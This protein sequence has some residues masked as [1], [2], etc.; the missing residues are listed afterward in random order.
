MKEPFIVF[1]I[2]CLNISNLDISNCNNIIACIRP[3][4]NKT[5]TSHQLNLLNLN[6]KLKFYSVFKKDC[7]KTDLLRKKFFNEINDKYPNFNDLDNISKILFLFNN[8]DPSVELL[9]LIFMI[10]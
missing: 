3:T 6:K 9:L 8:A 1:E 7:H 5:S 2:L 10:Q 4:V